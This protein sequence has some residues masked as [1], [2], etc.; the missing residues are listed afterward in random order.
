MNQMKKSELVK[1]IITEEMIEKAEKEA[2]ARM[3]KWGKS[4]RAAI[5]DRDV[6]G[7]LAH[8][9]V[10]NILD[11]WDVDYISYR[12]VEY[13]R[14]D[15][16][17]IKLR[18]QFLDVKGTRKNFNSKFFFNEEFLVFTDQLKKEVENIHQFVFVGL[19]RNFSKG[20]IYGII[21]PRKFVGLATD[22]KLKFDNKMVK[23]YHLKPFKDYVFEL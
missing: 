7:S 12:E 6:V 16:A 20:Y 3:S 18:E 14:G 1:F 4:T 22:V 21:E 23:A 5:Q 9:G 19:E 15:F 10:E 2:I 8:Q 11:L 13:A 17:D